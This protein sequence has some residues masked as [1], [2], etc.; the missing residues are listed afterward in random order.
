VTLPICLVMTVV[1]FSPGDPGATPSSAPPG[2]STRSEGHAAFRSPPTAAE[3]RLLHGRRDPVRD[4]EMARALEAASLAPGSPVDVERYTL[5]LKVIPPPV[6]RVEGTVRLEAR[7]LTSGLTRLDVGLYDVMAIGSI[8]S[9]AVPLAY[10]RAANTVAITLD[11]AYAAGD[12]VDVTIT[13]GGT[14]PSAGYGAFR[15]GTHDNGTQPI[16][17]TLSQPT[18]APVWWPCID[19]PA[20]KAIVQM[21]VNVPGDLVA[22][23]NGVLAGTVAEPDGTVTYQWRSGYPISTYLVS[24]AISN[25][26]TWTETY[27]PVTGGPP[28]PVQ[29]WVYPEHLSAAQTDLSVTVPMLEFFSTKFVEYPF[30]DEKYGHAIFNFGGGMEHQTATSYGASLIKGTH[31]YD[32]IVA[33]ELAHQW[34]G[35]SVSPASWDDIWLNEGFATYSEALWW[36]HRYGAA[37]LRAY[38]GSLDTRPF[39]GTVLAPTCGLFSNTVYD[40]G[41]WVMHMLRR[42][43]G[44]EAFFEGLRDYERAHHLSNASTADFQAAM[45]AASG[46]DLDDFFTQWL[47]RAGEPTFEWGWTAA[48]TPSGWVTYVRLDQIQG[49]APF[50]VPVDLLVVTASGSVKVTLD[51]T[52]TST[53]AVLPPLASQPTQVIFDPD[54]WLLETNVPVTLADADADG[55]PDGADNCAGA[56]NPAQP[57]LDGDGAGDACDSD[58]D[59]DGVDNAADCAPAEPRVADL[60]SETT[61]LEVVGA[62]VA[63]MTWDLQ[64]AGEP[65]LSWDL[66][67]GDLALLRPEGGTQGAVCAQARLVNPAAEDTVTPSPGAGVHYMVRR[68]NICGL[69]SLGAA[70]DGSLRNATACP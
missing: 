46:I 55:V 50:K 44:D 37:G 35:N 11:R 8:R 17:S 51:V 13:Y 16:I 22:V 33:H 30:A 59:G 47:T 67:R 65:G 58:I 9:G 41:G 54:Q 21:D 20:D 19:H 26:A 70:S 52:S 69:G 61:G 62:E 68:R 32:W 7:V 28:M 2:R 4:E 48:A 25:Y 40:K 66:L 38:A 53:E 3:R 14:P 24:L 6:K 34:W 29:H 49:G 60:P 31:Q 43:T 56:A 23:S 27:Q 36:E 12:L 10:T 63:T 5:A 18:Y 15:F 42:V 45:E 1:P 64:G 39:C 57:D